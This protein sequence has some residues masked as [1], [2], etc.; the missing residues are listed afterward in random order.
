MQFI[1]H[2]LYVRLALC[3][4]FEQFM[5]VVNHKLLQA[6]SPVRIIGHIAVPHIYDINNE[7]IYSGLDLKNCRQ[8]S[9]I[10]NVLYS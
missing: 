7:P 10:S 6:A 2:T 5:L 9:E 8:I 4:I 1:F 3:C